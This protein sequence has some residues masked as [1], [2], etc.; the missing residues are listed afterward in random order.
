MKQDAVHFLSSDGHDVQR[1]PPTL[2]EA[3]KA[4]AKEYGEE[5]AQALVETNPAAVVSGEALTIK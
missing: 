4:V 5:R 1:R 3:R 2:S